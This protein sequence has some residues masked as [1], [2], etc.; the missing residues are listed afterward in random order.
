M[1]MDNKIE[2]YTVENIQEILN[3]GRR[4]AYDLVNS[5]KFPAKK[6]ARKILIPKKTFNEWL[7]S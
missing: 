6:L 5:G 3:I 7:Y 4:Q 1:N 2:V